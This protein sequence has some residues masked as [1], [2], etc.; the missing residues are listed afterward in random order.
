VDTN[1]LQGHIASIF[2]V[3]YDQDMVSLDWLHSH[4][5]HLSSEKEDGMFLQNTGTRQ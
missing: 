5:T 2:R 1:V 3:E 4:R